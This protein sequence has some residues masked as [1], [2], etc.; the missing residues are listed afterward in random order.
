MQFTRE[1][2]EE[3]RVATPVYNEKRQNF[4]DIA[5]LIVKNFVGTS[6]N[7]KP[8]YKCGANLSAVLSRNG[9]IQHSV[10]MN[11]NKNSLSI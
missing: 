10:M 1:D 6:T 4:I 2:I 9:K 3:G 7:Y 11:Y 8:L 5:Q